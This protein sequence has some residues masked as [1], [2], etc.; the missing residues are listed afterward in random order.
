M[1]PYNSTPKSLLHLFLIMT[2]CLSCQKP[3]NNEPF[4]PTAYVNLFICTEGDN[5]MLYPGPAMP[6]GLVHL[7][8]E[9][10]GDSHVGYY[11]ENDSI[12]GFSH[13]RIAGAGSQGKGGGLLIKPG[14][15]LFTNKIK[16][17]SEPLIKSTEEASPGYYKVKLASGVTVELTTS[18]HVGF[19]RYTFPRDRKK[20]RY[21]VVDLSHS[22][23]GM[24]D[25]RLE[26][27]S[28]I[29]IAG[30]FKSLHNRGGGY[31]TLYFTIISDQPF[32]S[33][34]SW[35]GDD[36]GEVKER[37][38]NQTGVWLSYPED[39]KDQVFL[40]VGLSTVDENLARAEAL[41]EIKGWNFDQARESCADRWE[42]M[43][44]KVEVVD[45][46]DELKTIFYTHLYHSYLVPHLSSASTGEYRPLNQ[47]GL[48][49]QTKD[50]APD[51]NY[52]STWSLWDDFRKYSL[53]SLLEPSY[54]KN[55]V[56][57][58]VDVYANK[59][60]EGRDPKYSPTP[61]IRMEFN[62]TVIMDA[63]NKGIREFDSAIAY[64]GMKEY[65][66]QEDGKRISDQLEQ[67]YHA[68]V[69]MLMAKELGK[70]EDADLFYEKAMG[71]KRV[72]CPMQ[73][74]REGTVR[75]FFTPE[76]KEVDDVEDFEKHVYEGH[77]WHYRWFVLHDVEGLAQLRGS[78][79]LL[80]DDLEYFFEKD[81]FMIVNE[82]DLHAPYLFNYLDKPWLTQKWARRFTTKE[83]TQLYHNHG[84]YETPVVSR[85]FRAD[86]KGYIETMD[87]DAG[88]MASWFVMSAM[89]LFPLDPAL[90]Y[91][92]IGSPIFPEYR[93]HLDNGKHFTVKANNVSEDNFY[94][95]SA[96][97]NGEEFDQCWIAYDTIMAGGV[98]EFEMGN[99][100][101]KEWG[102]SVDIPSGMSE[103]GCVKK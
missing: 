51:F 102:K 78:K 19:H 92:L 4:N 3:T 75:G 29:E 38:G 28:E 44:R 6:F 87:D 39:G 24:L 1:Q 43:L 48:I 70:E 90:P 97:L 26:I 76:G 61:H 47:P 14:I 17:F 98:L 65:A 95:Q 101:N 36:C 79:E 56:R 77:L 74:D 21:I 30:Y 25:A 13:T 94:I 34:T 12:E 63:W 22:Y 73:K 7:S 27:R 5:G 53:V 88:A 23:V 9:T 40:K 58:L 54:T 62:S 99:R 59:D 80:A 91:Y 85:I 55:I 66:L 96:T 60:K 18:D 64:K 68:Y 100:P 32:A 42:K 31:H 45:G 71:Y 67:F 84:L 72:W 52:Y 89:G 57:S 81:L 82:P 37:Q 2:L 8:P 69:A 35:D 46:S 33:F 10:E 16:E 93:I 49:L 50:S 86:T 41:N 20:D 15:G 103:P 83:V 11:Y